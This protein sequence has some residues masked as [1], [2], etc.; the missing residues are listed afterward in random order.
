MDI[1]TLSLGLSLL[2]PSTCPVLEASGPP[3]ARGDLSTSQGYSQFSINMG[4]PGPHLALLSWALICLLI[5]LHLKSPIGLSLTGEVGAGLI[6]YPQDLARARHKA[7]CPC[8]PALPAFT[9]KGKFFLQGKE[10]N[11]S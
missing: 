2:P 9:L 11:N 4:A 7:D 5:Y 1:G 6:S 8:H 10:E 3:A